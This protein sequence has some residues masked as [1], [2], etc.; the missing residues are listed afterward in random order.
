[1]T[2]LQ[3]ALDAHALS[4][5]IDADPHNARYVDVTLEAEARSR[6][7]QLLGPDT[8]SDEAIAVYW[9]ELALWP[10]WGEWLAE[11]AQHPAV[12]ERWWA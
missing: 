9:Q 2:G 10:E 12:I 4:R 11:P 8:S 1:M 5:D 7:E 3:R 6:V